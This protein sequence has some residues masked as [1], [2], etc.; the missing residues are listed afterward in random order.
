MFETVFRPFG[1]T[2]RS[3]ALYRP[4]A[5][6]ESVVQIEIPLRADVDVDHIP[7]RLCRCGERKYV[8]NPIDYVPRP[9]S[10]PGPIFKSN[11]DFRASYPYV[12]V[13]QEL[14]RAIQAS[15]LRG[16]EFL[17]CRPA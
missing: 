4:R 7:Y 5:I 12:F 15:G 11:Q 2:S 10:G 17:P 8:R 1:I 6:L 3:V 13:S 9:R 14:Y 16:A